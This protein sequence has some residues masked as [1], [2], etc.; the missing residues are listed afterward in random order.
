MKL[1]I[2]SCITLSVLFIFQLA[3]QSGSV[4]MIYEPSEDYPFGRPNPEAPAEIKDFSPIIGRCDCKSVQRNSDGSWQDTLNM[5][6]QFK[7]IM[8]G[9]AVQ[10]EVWRENGMYAGSVRQYQPD[11]AKWVVTYFSYPAVSTKPGVWIG[12]KVGDEIVLTMPQKAPNGMDGLSR[13]TFY[14]MSH[15]GFRWKGEWVDTGQTFSYPFWNI[16]C[17]K[18]K[19]KKE[20]KGE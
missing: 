12:Q 18:R 8:N 13:L 3:A 16:S 1:R 17:V 7:Y 9:T 14:D 4:S 20:E 15:K 5:T 6:W 11:S 10:D 2:L 19:G